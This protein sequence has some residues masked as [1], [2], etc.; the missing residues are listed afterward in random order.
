MRLF[1]AIGQAI[2]LPFKIVNDIANKIY[3]AEQL[4]VALETFLMLVVWVC[5]LYIWWIKRAN[6]SVIPY[7]FG[8]ILI[9]TLISL[10]VESVW[11]FICGVLF[12]IS[13]AP[14][15]LY[16]EFGRKR[17]QPVDLQFFIKKEKKLNVYYAKYFRE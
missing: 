8:I 7:I 14:A 13:D 15:S 5:M 10:F 12:M 3:N 2:F 1:Y 9:N 16:H 17:K 6:S 11:M 4:R